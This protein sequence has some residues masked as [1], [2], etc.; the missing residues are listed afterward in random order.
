LLEQRLQGRRHRTV[1]KQQLSFPVSAPPL[2]R[3][4]PPWSKQS[5]N[6]RNLSFVPHHI[7]DCPIS[8]S[9]FDLHLPRSTPARLPTMS[10]ENSTV[11]VE[12]AAAAAGTAAPAPQEDKGKGKATATAEPADVDMD[13]DD[14]DEE[15]D[16]EVCGALDASPAS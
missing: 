15:D 1:N 16:E 6:T 11:P 5:L 8:I 12:D 3:H 9:E 14:D 4:F 13:E 7:T 2:P 10:S